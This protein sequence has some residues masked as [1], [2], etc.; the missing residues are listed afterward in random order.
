MERAGAHVVQQPA[1]PAQLL[2][3]HL[4][5]AV[6]RDVNHDLPQRT[7]ARHKALQYREHVRRAHAAPVEVDHC[8]ARRGA[9]D[10]AQ[11]RVCIGPSR[12]RADAPLC[13]VQLDL[14]VVADGH[15]GAAVR[16]VRVV[17]AAGG[18]GRAGRGGAPHA[19]AHAQAVMDTYRAHVKF[20]SMRAFRHMG[21][22][23]MHGE[24]CAVHSL[25]DTHD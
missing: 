4:G 9:I 11:R 13:R 8:E 17:I 2:P 15:D 7:P 19:S 24:A 20:A 16:G 1:R 6:V 23:A 3:R 21:A 14:V 18:L 25:S 5:G 22:R 10:G 12:R